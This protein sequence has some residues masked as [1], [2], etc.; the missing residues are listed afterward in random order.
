MKNRAKWELGDRELD[1][2]QVLWRMGKA[3]V[4]QV[5]EV[6]R[7]WGHEVAYTTIQTMLNRLVTKNYVARDES[8]RTHLYYALLEEPSAA[9]NA[10]KRLVERFFGGSVEGLMSQLV[11]KD[12]TAEQLERIQS[13]LSAHKR[14][15]KR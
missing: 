2:M 15:K 4:S 13:L 7:D 10:V 8:G 1:L 3:T 9:D 5:Q 11:E 12:L 6:L 14:G